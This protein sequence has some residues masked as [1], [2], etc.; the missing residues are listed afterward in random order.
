MSPVARW[1]RPR[2]SARIGACVP[3]PAPGAPSRTRTF[4]PFVVTSADEPLVVAHH[5]LRLDLL[6]GLDDHADDDEDAGA[7]EAESAELRQ[8]RRD[9]V[10]RD[11]DDAE[12]ER[13]GD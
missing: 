1:S 9:D 10:R 6:H 8:D 7:A 2:R 11:R 13:A 12:E 5:E 4:I 3:L